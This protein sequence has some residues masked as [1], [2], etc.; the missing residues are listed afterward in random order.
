VNEVPFPTFGR[1]Q[2]R[3]LSTGPSRA[4]GDADEHGSGW[5][6]HGLAALA[7]SALGLAVA[8]SVAV[9]TNAQT[10]ESSSNPLSPAK[11][12]ALAAPA[13]AG[14]GDGDAA[15]TSTAAGTSKTKAASARDKG[16][17]TAF[18]RR[19]V[20][21]LSRERV[22]NSQVAGQA[23]ERD[24][25]LSKTQLE[26]AIQAQLKASEDRASKLSAA[27][28]QTRK[29]QIQILEEKRRAAEAAKIAEEARQ[30]ALQQAR[31]S[32]DQPVTEQAPVNVPAQTPPDPAQ[33]DFSTVSSGGGARPISGGIIT[34]QFGA[35]GSWSR[36]HTGA[37]PRR[38]GR[39]RDLRRQ[40]R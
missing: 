37:D 29:N 12:Y 28:L 31:T 33:T 20:N 2:R 17:L 3:N 6:S 38:A 7:I 18:E 8:G 25:S 1:S 22:R 5:F 24:V 30:L 40:L 11:D 27:K 10:T 15:R 32:V 35:V 26:L 39:R 36:Y 21:D 34:A 16:T 14:T 19:T 23:A 13:P 4:D 9:T